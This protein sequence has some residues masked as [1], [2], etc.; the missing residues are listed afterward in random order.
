MKWR[1]CADDGQELETVTEVVDVSGSCHETIARASPLPTRLGAAA[2]NPGS[3]GQLSRSDAHSFSY[4]LA[5]ATKGLLSKLLFVSLSGFVCMKLFET[6]HFYLKQ[7][8]HR[9]Y[10]RK[11]YAVDVR[12][13]TLKC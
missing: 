13:N 12:L 1:S 4:S 6:A 5:P 10:L 3:Q 7:V 9:C 8:F 11:H 2:V